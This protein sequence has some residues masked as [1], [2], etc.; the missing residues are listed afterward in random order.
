[1]GH[2]FFIRST[3]SKVVYCAGSSRECRHSS[4]PT[5]RFEKQ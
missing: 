1:M 4:E 5:R 2:V 3:L